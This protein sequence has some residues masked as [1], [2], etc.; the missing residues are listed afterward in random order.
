MKPEPPDL[1]TLHH[2]DK[3]GA[4]GKWTEYPLMLGV[5]SSR[6]GKLLQ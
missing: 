3:L 6:I 5:L 4:T 2:L 1:T